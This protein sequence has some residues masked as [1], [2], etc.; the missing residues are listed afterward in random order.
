MKIPEEIKL[1]ARASARSLLGS[2]YVDDYYDGAA[3]DFIWLYQAGYEQA[4]HDERAK[5]RR[6]KRA[7]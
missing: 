7:A 1:D 4:I 6:K 2:G 3:S 5:Q